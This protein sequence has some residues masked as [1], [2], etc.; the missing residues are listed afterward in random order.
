MLDAHVPVNVTVY[1]MTVC[2][3]GYALVTGPVSEPLPRFNEPPVTAT[4][5]VTLPLFTSTVVSEMV[6][7]HLPPPSGG[8][9][10]VVQVP[11]T[12]RGEVRYGDGRLTVNLPLL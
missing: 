3:P 6:Q 12:G 7:V 2:G 4:E 5:P 10:V 11:A 1:L 9:T 8:G